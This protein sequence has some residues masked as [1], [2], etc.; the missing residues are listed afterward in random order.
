M[1]AGDALHR[2]GVR[3][4]SPIRR[5]IPIRSSAPSWSSTLARASGP[6][7]MAGGQM[8]DLA[9]ESEPLRPAD[10]DPA[11]AA[12]DRRADRL[13]PR[14]GRDPGPCRRP[15]AARTCAAMRA[16]SASPSR[17]PTI[18]STSRAT[19]RCAARR[20]GKDAAAGKA[21]LRLAARRRARPRAGA[22]AGRPGDRASRALRHRGRPAARA[23]RA[24]S[25]NGIVDGDAAVTGR[26]SAS[27]RARSIR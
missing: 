9:A 17:S 11:A 21:D 12:Q 1:L 4:R 22:D 20:L 26:A 19:R 14:G 7:G 15:R 10:V 16:T 24:T 25:S 18:C 3:G 8:M 2:A 27:I 23:S 6:S 5:R 13:L